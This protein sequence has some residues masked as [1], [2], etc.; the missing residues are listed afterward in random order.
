MDH[1][2]WTSRLVMVLHTEVRS[3]KSTPRRII[4]R[5]VDF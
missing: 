3:Q 2:G 1:N 5:G 4:R